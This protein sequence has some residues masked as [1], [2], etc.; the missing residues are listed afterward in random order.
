MWTA[1]LT[2]HRESGMDFETTLSDHSH[3]SEITG[4][5]PAVTSF[6]NIRLGIACPM[7][8]EEATAVKFVDAVLEQVAR[9][10]FKSVTFIAVL[11]RAC[12][13]QTLA[14]LRE[15]S[16]H[17][18]ELRVVWAPENTCVVDAYVRGYREAL[19]ANSDWIL[20]ID[21]GFSHQPADIPRFFDL[22]ARGFDCVFGSRFCPGGRMRESSLKRR[23]ISRG[24]SLL[25][26]AM[27]G[28]KLTDMTSGF[29]LFSRS[30]LQLV[31]ERGI[32]SRSP[33]FQ[34]EIKFHCRHLR[35]AETPI[36]YRAGSHA[37]GRKALTDSLR[38]LVRLRRLR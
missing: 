14:L 21:A 15:H 20:E 24:G 10:N 26:N 5:E 1:A 25:A 22:M 6:S 13:D 8:S 3:N 33:F 28:T 29:E 18:P 35:I 12:R 19:D 30:A 31:L 38:S 2:P 4:V 34:T 32:E 27:L 16:H 36:Q 11:D 23:L 37:V 17:R 7:A 9:N